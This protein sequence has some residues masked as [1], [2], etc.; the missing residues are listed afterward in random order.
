MGVRGVRASAGSGV[1]LAVLGVAYA[2]AAMTGWD[3]SWGAW[4]R[5]VLH[6]GE[7]AVVMAL[8]ALLTNVGERGLLGRVGWAAA[9]IGQ[10]LLAVAEVVYPAAPDL[11]DT[12]FGIGPLLS[13]LGMICVGI[14]VLRG[15]TLRWRVLPLIVGTWILVPVTPVLI[16]TGG[17]PNPIALAAIATWDVL[18]AA[19]AAAVLLS[20]STAPV[21]VGV[22]VGGRATT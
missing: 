19:T 17:P 6:L 7:L 11:G 1:V 9:G 2:V 20:T 13:G 21:G 8:A 22:P 14:V 15:R 12:L 5:A 18:W 4:F 3:P 10:L 16:A